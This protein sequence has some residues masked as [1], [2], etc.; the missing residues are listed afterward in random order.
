MVIVLGYTTDGK[1]PTIASP[2]YHGP[3]RLERSVI[4]AA[5]F[6]RSGQAVGL[7]ARRTYHPY[8]GGLREPDSR[9]RAAFEPGLRW[10]KAEYPQNSRLYDLMEKAKFAP[11]ESG[12][13]D[14]YS[15]SRW[16]DK[17]RFGIL[18]EGYFRAPRDG[19]YTF[20]VKTPQGAQLFIHNPRIELPAPPVAEASYR[21][22]EGRGS[23]ALRAGY[24]KM[25]IE[26]MRHVGANELKVY[27]EGPGFRRRPLPPEWLFRQRV[28]QHD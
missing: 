26:Y 16:R 1:E 5:R 11:M 19:L 27:V 4:V 18:Y 25:R 17:S 15:P 22:T 23:T 21:Q 9:E 2:A 14:D 7:T 13:S 28:P 20:Y 24:H 10:R 3:I 12:V 8:R 6:F